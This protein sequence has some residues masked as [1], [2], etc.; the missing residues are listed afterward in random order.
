MIL[1]PLNGWLI[2]LNGI[3]DEG[4]LLVIGG[5]GEEDGLLVGAVGGAGGLV[6]DVV[7]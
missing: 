7:D 3:Q 1:A 4:L 6:E 5:G 2:I